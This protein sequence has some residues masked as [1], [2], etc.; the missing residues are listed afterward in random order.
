MPTLLLGVSSL[1]SVSSPSTWTPIAMLCSPLLLTVIIFITF[2]LQTLLNISSPKV[3][4]TSY[5]MTKGN[6]VQAV[7]LPRDSILS[8]ILTPVSW[9][10]GYRATM[11]TR[12]SRTTHSWPTCSSLKKK[13]FKGF[14]LLKMSS[15]DNSDH[16]CTKNR[17]RI[18][19]F[20]WIFKH[21]GCCAEWL[22]LSTEFC[23]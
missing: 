2:K 1:L 4:S 20:I 17:S 16:Y 11:R 7:D 21:T 12:S 10:P 14:I 8:S 18:I 9:T 22:F 19:L 13:I 5:W 23:L 3:M 6:Y 15:L